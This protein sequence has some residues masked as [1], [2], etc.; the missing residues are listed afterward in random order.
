MA[1]EPAEAGLDLARAFDEHARGLLRYCAC[2]VGPDAAED[3]VA[4]TFLVAHSRRR[5][6][7]PTR[8]AASTWLYGIATRLLRG[9]RRAESR[10]LGRLA[11]AAQSEVDTDFADGAVDRLHAQ[12]NHRRVARAVAKLPA[13]QRE[14][15]LLVA[16]AE[17]EYAEV[18]AAL[19]IPI[20]TVRSALH[21][22]RTRLRA[23]LTSGGE[24]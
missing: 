23:A 1:L 24:L 12:A 4:Q 10:R 8:G 18:A 9:H 11:Q 14:V 3:V 6:F 16:M 2:R 19:D 17:L 21:R 22:A 7:D 13:R 15:L 20:G 5:D